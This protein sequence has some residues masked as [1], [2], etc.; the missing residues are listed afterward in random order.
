MKQE[1][2]QVL[3][4]MKGLSQVYNYKIDP[5]DL[6]IN[7]DE[8]EKQEFFEELKSTKNESRG[9]GDTIEKITKTTGIK[10]AISS[11]S[12]AL[13]KDCGCNNRKD[14]LNKAFPYKNRKEL[15]LERISNK[16]QN[17]EN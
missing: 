13:D 17:G 14:F 1:W 3:T 5:R 4:K 15:I 2:K 12:N 8:S 16:I 10:K 7:M 11:I 9:L 6:F